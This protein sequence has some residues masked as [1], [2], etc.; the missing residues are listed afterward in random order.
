LHVAVT[1]A[2]SSRAS[3]L[4]IILNGKLAQEIDAVR[5]AATTAVANSLLSFDEYIMK[6]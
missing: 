6:R 1:Y 5:L 2:G 4:E 3:G